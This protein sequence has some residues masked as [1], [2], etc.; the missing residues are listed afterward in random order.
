M[1]LS[2]NITNFSWP[3]SPA[4]IRVHL[5]EIVR[6]ADEAGLDTVWVNDH[7]IQADPTSTPDTEML[8]AYTTLGFLAARTERVRL[9]TMVTAVSYRPAGLLIKAVT[10]LDVLS[11]GR[12]WLGIG[13]G[14]QEDEARAM[15]LPLP[16]V[17]ER[18]ERLEETLRLAKQMW[19]GDPSPFQSAHYRLERPVNNPNSITRPHP[20][21]LVGGTGE[22]RTLRLVAEHADACGLFDIPDGGETIRRKLTVL[23]GHCADV[24]RNPADIEKTVSTRLGADESPDEFARRCAALAALGMEHA[25]VI[26]SG[27]WTPQQVA[28][29]AAAVPAVSG[30]EA[31]QP[32]G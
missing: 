4:G 17:R 23:A 31:A 20:P 3:D 28:T 27:P 5:A 18:F 2:I 26:V 14:Y 22:R 1:R 21:I 9:G 32:A 10:T 6:A 25:V 11:G 12:A 29:L 15:G 13:A 16:P 30:I 24:G 7:L 19:A 8:E